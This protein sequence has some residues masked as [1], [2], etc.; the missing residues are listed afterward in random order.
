LKN[1]MAPNRR[2]HAQNRVTWCI[3]RKKKSVSC[4]GHAILLMHLETVS[5]FN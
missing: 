1:W 3:R 5:Q 2:R 4:Q